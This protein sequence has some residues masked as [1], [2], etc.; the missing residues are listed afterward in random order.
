M[1]TI[2]LRQYF[3]VGTIFIISGCANITSLGPDTYLIEGGS[4]VTSRR[5]EE[6]CSQTGKK[7]LVTNLSSGNKFIF[8]CVDPRSTEYVAPKFETAPNTIIEDRRTK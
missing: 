4:A 2:V 5:A 8:K 7:V 1:K 3:Y 6:L